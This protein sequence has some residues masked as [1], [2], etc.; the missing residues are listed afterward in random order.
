MTRSN[1]H[2]TGAS[3]QKAG[4]VWGRLLALVPFGIGVSMTGS[5]IRNAEQF[6]SVSDFALTGVF[7]LFWF[8]LA[9]WLWRSNRLL[10]SYFGD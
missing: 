2:D 7:I 10:S 4:R 8:A 5:S 9:V 3:D 1:T 6:E